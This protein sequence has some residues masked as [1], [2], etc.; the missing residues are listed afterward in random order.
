MSY[1]YTTNDG[2]TGVTADNVYDV[3]WLRLSHLTT[4]S[5]PGC[6]AFLGRPYIVNDRGRGMIDWKHGYT[7]EEIADALKLYNAECDQMYKNG[8]TGDFGCGL[9]FAMATYMPVCW[10]HFFKRSAPNFTDDASESG[11]T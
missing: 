6:R 7:D 3:E 10:Q 8:Y 4:C 5:C 11:G 9:S 1:S 2:K